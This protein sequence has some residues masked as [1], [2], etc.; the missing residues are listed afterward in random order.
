MTRNDFIE[1]IE[2]WLK[3]IGQQYSDEEDEEL[4][5]LIIKECEKRLKEINSG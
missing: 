2:H 1:N 5:E 3:L 4:Y